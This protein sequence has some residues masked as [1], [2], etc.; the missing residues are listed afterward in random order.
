MSDHTIGGQAEALRLSADAVP[1]T[2]ANALCDTIEVLR[3]H[4]AAILGTND[5]IVSE[6]HRIAETAADI[7][8][9]LAT[10][11]AKIENAGNYHHGSAGAHRPTNIPNPTA[12]PQTL[13]RPY[14]RLPKPLISKP[15]P[16]P[17]EVTDDPATWPGRIE[18]SGTTDEQRFSADEASVA[19]RLAQTGRNIVRRLPT[20]DRRT[21]DATV[22]GHAVEFKTLQQKDGKIPTRKTVKKMLRNSQKNGGQSSDVIIDARR[23]GLTQDDA[24]SGLK[25]FVNAP[26]NESKLT[27]V[28]IWGKNFDFNWRRGS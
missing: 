19:K 23:T 26:G 5:E 3:D 4:L 13:D 27:R 11:R 28:R 17:A 9:A 6:A 20:S 14:D 8:R 16:L 10:L 25:A 7:V 18:D 22:N 12:R 1:L 2:Y 21:A 24:V 15:Q